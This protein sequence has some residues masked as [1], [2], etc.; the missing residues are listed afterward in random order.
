MVC[1]ILFGAGTDF[2]TGIIWSFCSGEDL[3]A[4]SA[5]P[6]PKGHTNAFYLSYSNHTGGFSFAVGAFHILSGTHFQGGSIG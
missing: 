2:Y 6:L 4:G 1:D 3:L 5:V